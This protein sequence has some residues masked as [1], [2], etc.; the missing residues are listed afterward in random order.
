MNLKMV[1]SPYYDVQIKP[2]KSFLFKQN[3]TKKLFQCKVI[4]H[5]SLLTLIVLITCWQV[6]SFWSNLYINTSWNKSQGIRVAFYHAIH[7]ARLIH[8]TS[9]FL[10]R[11]Y[12]FEKK[13]GRV[14]FRLQRK[15]GRSRKKSLSLD[16]AENLTDSNKGLILRPVAMTEGVERAAKCQLRPVNFHINI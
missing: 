7:T 16:W 11:H 6:L 8:T 12:A 5:W 2:S 15:G 1:S 14:R 3:S 4:G 10:R 9:S 13:R